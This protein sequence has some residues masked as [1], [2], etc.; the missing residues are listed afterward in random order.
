MSKYPAA[1]FGVFFGD[2]NRNAIAYP[3][4]FGMANPVFR[5]NRQRR[6]LI[7]QLFRQPLIIGIQKGQPF[8]GCLLYAEIS[9]RT[10]AKMILIEI[11]Y[12]WKFA[13]EHDVRAV[14]RAVINDRNFSC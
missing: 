11:I 13:A 14:G 2:I 1:G 5:I 12:L 10:D 8:A 3:V 9:R 4:F 6:L 7:E